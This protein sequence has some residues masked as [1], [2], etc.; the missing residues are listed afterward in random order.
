MTLRTLLAGE[1]RS[2]VNS[3][4]QWIKPRVAFDK[5]AEHHKSELRIEEHYTNTTGLTDH[6]FALCHFLGFDFAPRIADL[7]DKG[8]GHNQTQCCAQPCLER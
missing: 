5:I 1:V 6:V 7:T 3:G 4:E 2:V 8:Y